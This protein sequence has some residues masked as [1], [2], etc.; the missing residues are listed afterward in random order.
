MRLVAQFADRCVAMSDGRII[1]DGT[2]MELFSSPEILRAANL[3]PPP[4]FDFSRDLLG[5]PRLHT[6][7]VVEEMEVSLGRSGT[8]VQGS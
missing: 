8:V 5:T 3:K 4:V 2:P 7:Q 1:Y 6:H